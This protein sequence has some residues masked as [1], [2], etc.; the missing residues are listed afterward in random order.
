[1]T[2][3]EQTD[4][5][6]I[7]QRYAMLCYAMRQPDDPATCRSPYFGKNY[8]KPKLFEYGVSMPHA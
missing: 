3:V 1:M 6:V 4:V 7:P 5:Q 8:G 2:S